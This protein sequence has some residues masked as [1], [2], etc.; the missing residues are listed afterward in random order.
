L[1]QRLPIPGSDD[2]TWGDILNGFLEVSHNADGTLQT[3]ALTQAGAVT[4]VNSVSPTNGAVTLTPA[5][6][7][8]GSPSS[9]N[10]LRGDGTWVVPNSGSSTLAADTDVTIS[11]PANNQVLIFNSSA[12]KWENLAA[13]NSLAVNGGS[14]Q[15][16]AVSITAVQ[17]AGDIGGT[18]TTPTVTSTHLSSA[19]PVN[20]GGTGSI[21][22]NF[23]DLSSS[24]NISGAKSFSAGALLDEGNQIWNVKA[25]GATGNGTT[26]DTTSV[27][28]A[29]NAALAA[30]GG[31][32][33]FPE[34][35]YVMS[36]VTFG[37]NIT[38]Y[39]AGLGNTV[40]LMDPNSVSGAVVCRVAPSSSSVST[41]NCLVRDLTIDGNKSIWGSNNNQKN[42]GYYM[43]QATQN[44]ISYCWMENVEIRNC[45][46]YAFDIENVNNVTLINCWAH[47]NGY[48]SGTGTE[49]S[50]DGFTFIGNDITA[51]GCRS[52]L[53]SARGYQ[54][55]QNG[56]NWYRVKLIGCSA[57][58]NYIHGVILGSSSG[59]Y[60]Y[61]SEV[62]GGSFINSTTGCGIEVNT[63]CQRSTIS[64]NNCS[65]NYQYGI[66]I[67]AAS[68][69]SIIGN[70]L[71]NNSLEG[72]TEG[73]LY[74]T[75]SSTYNTITG[76]TITTTNANNAIGEQNSSTDYNVIANNVVSS[77]STTIS[78]N[79]THTYVGD[80]QG[81]TSDVGPS[82]TFTGKVITPSLQVTTGSGT[83][84]QVLTSD[85]S[86]NATWQ[87]VTA[88]ASGT[89]GGD[90][91]GTYPNPT[92]SGTA[93]VE[94]IIAA[95]TTVTGKMTT[96]TYDPAAIAQQVLGTTATQSFSNK[97][98]TRRVIGVTQSATP[99][100]DTDNMDVASIT[101][102]AQGIT[103]MTSGLSGTPNA[104][105]TLIVQITDNNTPQTI[106]WGTK[107]EA[108]STISPPTITVASTMVMVGFMWN[109]VTSKWRCIAVA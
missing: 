54:V 99:S 64:G 29:V 16:G 62:I 3:T 41:S 1:T 44:L 85:L 90:L 18:A 8:T 25:Y 106:A 87:N 104:G 10:F 70:T 37:S 105:D 26:V 63:G 55:G 24:Q 60:L 27:Q 2:G 46:T 21:T 31:S 88:T 109:T 4:T 95:N 43:G 6:L 9:S 58:G 17:V 45:L 47:D 52:N 81:Y 19:L 28:N 36:N 67:S 96:A 102:L 22:Q 23:V 86:G 108:S 50:C 61:D 5:S 11:S 38:V 101:G 76:N 20:Q 93:N 57:S 42:Y 103:S 56:F 14:A 66:S 89:A 30:G 15:T 39:G 98:Y 83:A 77:L 68:Y 82:K 107:F 92:L 72:A 80:N 74:L 100:I 49:H 7:G 13:V 75:N 51:I 73:E 79:G 97:R 78:I 32:V 84:S 65:G 59:T 35:T 91:T 94:S 34:G 12:G 48:S 40:L 33:F 71:Y 69:N 53:N